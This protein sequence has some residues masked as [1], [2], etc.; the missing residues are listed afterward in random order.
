MNFFMVAIE[1]YFSS[2]F[3]MNGLCVITVV[4]L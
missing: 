2:I 3:M 4:T 1:N